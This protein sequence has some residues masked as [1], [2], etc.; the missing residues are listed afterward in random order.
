MTKTVGSTKPKIFAILC[1]ISLSTPALDLDFRLLNTRLGF[2]VL[3]RC[4]NPRTV[5]CK[6]TYKHKRR[7]N[8]KCF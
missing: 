8:V 1:R 4:I 7:C 6:W 5:A 2:V 3:M